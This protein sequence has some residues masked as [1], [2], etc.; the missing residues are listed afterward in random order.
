[1]KSIFSRANTILGSIVLVGS[2][3]AGIWQSHFFFP[4]LSFDAAVDFGV[5]IILSVL[6]LFLVGLVFAGVVLSER[7]RRIERKIGLAPA[8][9]K[10]R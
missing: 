9:E 8:L 5:K 1:M 2:I 6:W 10:R 4:T 3:T 7:F